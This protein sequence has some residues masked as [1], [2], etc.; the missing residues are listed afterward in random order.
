MLDEYEPIGSTDA[1][2]FSTTKHCESTVKSHLSHAVCDSKLEARMTRQLDQNDY[3]VSFAKNDRLFLEIPFR[4][5]GKSLRYRPDFLVLLDT[6]ERLLIEGKADE[7]DDAKATA[8]RRWVAAVN[9]WR[10]LGVWHHAI[11]QKESEIASAIKRVLAGT[12]EQ[13]SETA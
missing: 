13:P 4:F 8:A 1:I 10:K 11:C 7:K 5:L 2:A 12:T 3:V 6:G 9:E